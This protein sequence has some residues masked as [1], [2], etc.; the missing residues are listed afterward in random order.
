MCEIILHLYFW[1]Q[2]VGSEIIPIRE[3]DPD[4]HYGRPPKSGS[5]SQKSSNICL[6][7]AFYLNLGFCFFKLMM[8]CENTQKKQKSN[9]IQVT[10]NEK[11]TSFRPICYSLHP[12]LDPDSHAD[13]CGSMIRIRIILYNIYGSPSL[14]PIDQ[15][16]LHF[17]SETN[18]LLYE[19]LKRRQHSRSEL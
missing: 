19:L 9:I 3:L 1:N 17:A 5:R 10:L 13:W 12:Y 16:V 7:S 18:C 6:R 4:P 8:H 14:I 15:V 11:K 2:H